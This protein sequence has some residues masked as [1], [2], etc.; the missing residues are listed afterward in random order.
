VGAQR[1]AATERT[2]ATEGAQTDT[3]CAYER[4]ALG[5]APR[6]NGLAV[7]RGRSGL[8]VAN[9]HFFWPRDVSG[10][11]AGPDATA[12]GADS[13]GAAAGRAVRLR[14]VGAALTDGGVAFLAAAAAAAI[15]AGHARR[16]DRLL[17]GAGVTMLGVS[18]P[19][20]FAADGALSRAV[21]W[22]NARYTR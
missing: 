6:W 1:A 17:V 10:T 21:W 9:L 16:N 14:R 19:L 20:Q 18:V 2:G 4:C 3:A 11:L 12:F 5:I 8:R 22:H 13:A 15:A 7:V